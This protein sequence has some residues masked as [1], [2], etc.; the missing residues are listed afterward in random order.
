VHLGHVGA[1]GD[2]GVGE[3]DVVVTA[4]RLV[5][6]E[7]LDER[8]H[9]RRHAM[10]GV[11]V[12]VVGPPAGLGQ[13][14]RRVTLGDRVLAGPHDA[15]PGRAEL[16]V[17]LLELTFHLVERA[18]PRDLGK[19][20]VLVETPV[21][22]PQERLRQPVLAIEDVGVGVALGA[23]KAAIDR[24]LRIA[25][26]GRHVAVAGADHHS[27]ADAAE[28]ADALFPGDTGFDGG[29]IPGFGHWHA[30]GCSGRGGDAGLDEV[31]A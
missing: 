15:D 23:Q 7:D 6:A 18:L 26:D 17:N 3:L 25:L 27:A 1:P 19:I 21:L 24:I 16:A 29:G 11:G 14:D 22:H 4:G 2:D 9:S 8:C 30:D 12:D 31:P 13:L 20:A 5:D 28:A 10:A